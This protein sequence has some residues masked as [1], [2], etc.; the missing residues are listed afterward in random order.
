MSSDQRDDQAVGPPWE[1][2]PRL[3]L[4]TAE[5]LEIAGGRV[6]AELVEDLLAVCRQ[7]N[8]ILVVSKDHIQDIQ[9]AYATTREGFLDALER[10]PVVAAV[11]KEPYQVEPWADDPQ[12]ISLRH[13]S[14]VRGLF[15]H[16]TTQSY[17][18]L[19]ADTQTALQVASARTQ[20]ARRIAPPYS[21]IAN[22]HRIRCI[23]MLAR[24]PA[25]RDIDEFLE[26]CEQETGEQLES[27]E[28]EA[29]TNHLQPWADLLRDFKAKF[30]LTEEQR[31][32]FAYDV[33]ATIDGAIQHDA[34]GT[35]LARCLA[36]GLAQNPT[37]KPLRSDTVDSAH[38][39]YFP[40]VDIATCDREVFACISRQ[41]TEVHGPRPTKLFRN[42]QLHRVV[43]TLSLL[44]PQP[45]D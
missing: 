4:D 6:D 19:F 20:E 41:I 27:K 38:A 32:D 9:G 26:E 23:L 18:Q 11:D 34:P 42:G 40:Y 29:I 39:S 21:R 43:E 17:F 15:Q 10:F 1:K 13:V 16:P 3:Y 8:T 36:R 30:K 14:D 22:E 44:V 45:S 12:D 28:R 24:E 31:T 25:N 2:W 5:L 37:R 33:A 7:S 35:G